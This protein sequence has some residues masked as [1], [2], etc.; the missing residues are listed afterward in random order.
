MPTELPTND[1]EP[2]IAAENGRVEETDESTSKPTES[3]LKSEK[4]NILITNMC[5]IKSKISSLCNITDTFNP[6]VTLISETH[7]CQNEKPPLKGRYVHYNRNRNSDKSSS[8]GGVSVT[9][10]K[11]LKNECVIVGKGEKEYQ[12]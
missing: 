1:K 4:A 6:V 12:C 10:N 3:V 8:K 11:D 9:V 5:G 7:C 2:R